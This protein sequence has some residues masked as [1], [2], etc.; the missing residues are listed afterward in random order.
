MARVIFD[1]DGTLI[2]SAPTIA[3]AANA[4]VA[5]LGREVLPME[6]VLGFVG[7][8][9]E[10]LVT[11]M[12]A[13]TGGVPAEGVAPHLARYRFLY[14]A[15]PLTGTR[16]YDGVHAALDALAVAG[17]GLGVCTQK[18]VAPSRDILRGFGLMPPVTALTGGDSIAVLKPDPAMLAHTAQQL[19]GGPVIFVGD[20][21]TDAATAANAGVPFVLHLPGYRHGPLDEIARAAEFEDFADLPGIVAGLMEEVGA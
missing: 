18:P 19:A 6:T 14:E 21:E 15:D 10:R 11:R 2:D 12:L 4:L 17:H 16:V 1:L 8:G 20:S 7:H 13:A 5:E 3:A 9:M